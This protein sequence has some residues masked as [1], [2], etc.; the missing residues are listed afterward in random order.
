VTIEP[1]SLPGATFSFSVRLGSNHAPLASPGGPY[2][3][4]AGQNVGF[5]ASGSSDEDGDRLTYQWNFGDGATGAGVNPI[6][7]YG[8]AGTYTVTLTVSDS[9]AAATSTTTAGIVERMIAITSPN[10]AVNWTAGTTQT[11]D[12]IHNLGAGS[13]VDVDLSRDGGATWNAIAAAVTNGSATSGSLAWLVTGPPTSSA[14]LRVRTA[15]GTTSDINDA[16]LTISSLNRPPVANTG[17]PY[18]GVAGRAIAF[19][20]AGSSDADGDALTYQ[21]TFGDGASGAG[22]SPTR[23]YAAAGT[24][25]VTLVVSDGIATATSTTTATIAAQTISVTAPNAAVNWGV[26]S[27]QLI[28]WTH[29]LGTGSTVRIDV[30]RDG[31]VTWSAIAASVTNAGVASG[32]YAWVVTGPATASGQI[33]V[34]AIS[35]SG[36]DA[37]DANFTI[38]APFI[39]VSAPKSG[40]LWSVG[41]TYAISWKHNLGTTGAV[42]IEISRNGG[43]TWSVLAGSVQNSGNES[44][45]YNWTATAPTTTVARIRVSWTSNAGVFD[46]SN[47]NFAIR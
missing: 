14:R 3:G 19:T 18:S 31:G 15:S 46:R 2:S 8:A 27:T 35:G 47:G 30:S 22:V 5:D 45:S 25:T 11:I 4:V 44:G 34:S 20:A 38:A 24:Y 29:N 21:W 39:T 33:R 6:H 13:T 41:T 16:D 10:T 28:E 9:V 1:T 26:G 40:A 12:W 32:S 36:S 7:A 23:V 37:S 43:N 17:G 42:K